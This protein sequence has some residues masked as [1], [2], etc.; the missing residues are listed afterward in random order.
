MI[1]SKT[2]YRIS[3]F[4]GGS[5]YPTWYLKYNGAQFTPT[6]EIALMRGDISRN[7]LKIIRVNHSANVFLLL[8][9]V[10]LLL[11]LFIIIIIIRVCFHH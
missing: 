9:I 3:F 4:G 11:L 10:L 5:D 6:N 1:I 7:L 8:Y 2:P